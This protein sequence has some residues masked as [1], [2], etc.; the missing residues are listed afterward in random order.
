MKEVLFLILGIAGL[1]LAAEVLIRSLQIIAHRKGISETFLG[2]TVLS[3]GTSFPEIGTHILASIDILRGMP[4]SGIAVGANIG[5]NLMQITLILGLTAFF[6]HVYADKKFLKQ[7][8][9]VMLGSI[10]LIFVMS[11]NGWISR[12]EGIILVVLYIIYLR[13]LGKQEHFVREVEYHP[14]KEGGLAKY[15]LL[16]IVGLIFLWFTANLVVGS[17]VTISQVFNIEGSLIG[18]LVIGFGTALPEF[19]TAMTALKKKSEGMS[20]G[21]LVGSNIT[22]PLL[23]IGIGAAISGYVIDKHILWFDLPAWFFVSLL[24]L[25]FFIRKG[26]ITKKEATV[27]MA[28]Y[29]VYIL[30]RL[31]VTGVLL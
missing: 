11:I 16:T 28:S 15:Y 8:Y 30:L 2:L 14:R 7:D 24:A 10:L 31:K 21:V 5:S 17:A 3:I 27:M 19:V 29:F 9:A 26:H 12:V 23:G 4:A 6:M 13:S 1:L 22:N 18:A 20:L 25:F